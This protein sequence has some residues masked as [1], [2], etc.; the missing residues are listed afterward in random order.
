MTTARRA[1]WNVLSGSDGHLTADEVAIEVSHLNPDVNLS[2]VYRSLGLFEELGLVRGTSIQ[3]GG[4][5]HWELA[6][7]DDSFHLKC[8]SCGKVEH[9]HGDLVD[10]VRS[11][12]QEDHG[13]VPEQIDLVVTGLCPVCAKL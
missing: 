13:F 12:L 3:S 10:R 1:V 5:A 6:H 4:P 7:P 11:H 2:S 9:H 8:R